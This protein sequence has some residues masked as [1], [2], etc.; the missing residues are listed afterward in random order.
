M[1]VLIRFLRSLQKRQVFI[2]LDMKY[3]IFLIFYPSFRTFFFLADPDFSG[4]DKDFRPIR[5]REKIRITLNYPTSVQP[6][7]FLPSILL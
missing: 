7:G 6:I 3:N 2:M 4:Q 5:I 1:M